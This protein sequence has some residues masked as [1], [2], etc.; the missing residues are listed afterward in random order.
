MLPLMRPQNFVPSTVHQFYE[1]L[2][3]AAFLHRLIDV[4]HQPELPAL[5]LPG[6]TVFPCGKFSAALLIGRQDTQVMLFADLVTDPAK[7]AQGVGILPEF[8]PVHEADGVDHKVG[9]DMLGIAV[10]GYLHLISGPRFLC[11]RSCNLMRLLGSDILPG[12]EGLNVLVEVDAVHF[13]V[14]SLRCQ[15]F[16]GG[17]ATVTEDAADQLSPR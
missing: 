2:P 10:G 7:L 14:G 6:S 12:M 5:I 11:K 4:V 17:I 8:L 3:T 15:K 16:R 1:V 9:M 13:V